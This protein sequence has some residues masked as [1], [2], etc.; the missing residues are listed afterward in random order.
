VSEQNKQI[1]RDLWGCLSSGDF[2]KMG[3]L[4]DENVQY[5]GSGGEERRGRAAA[6]EFAKTYKVAFPDM[7]AN[8]EQ[9]I[10]EGDYVV[11]RVN[12]SGTNT[13]E[14]MGMPPTGKT[15]DLKWVMNMVRIHN[16]KIVEEWEVFDS[17]DFMRQLGMA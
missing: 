15:V 12:P 11:S 2:D 14:M 1:V 10:A 7:K 4:Y 3:Q 13:G 9:L 16:G 17:A 5:H 8:V 6:V